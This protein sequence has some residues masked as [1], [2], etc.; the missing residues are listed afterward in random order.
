VWIVDFSA[1]GAQL[2]TLSRD[3]PVRL[4]IASR[5][6]LLDEAARRATRNLTHAEWRQFLPDESYPLLCDQKPVHPSVA[7]AA[8]DLLLAGDEA[9]GLQLCGQIA[10]L[11]ARRPPAAALSP[12]AE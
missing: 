3:L 6:G 7:A 12:R 10:R 9:G 1:D 4:W 8:A 2:A 11:N 5:E